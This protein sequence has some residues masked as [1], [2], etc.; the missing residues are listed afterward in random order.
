MQWINSNYSY[1][2]VAYIGET[3]S[4]KYGI[5]FV[6]CC[7]VLGA[8]AVLPI[9]VFNALDKRKGYSNLL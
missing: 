3:T 1:S 5:I 9:V 7:G 4:E 2:F 8:V 6:G